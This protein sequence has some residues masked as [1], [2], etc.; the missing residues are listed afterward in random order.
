LLSEK[1]PYAINVADS[2]NPI[3]IAQSFGNI[4][5]NQDVMRESIERFQRKE[6]SYDYF[7]KKVE[8][9]VFW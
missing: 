5:A 6:G 7:A 3:E 8:K 1:Y 4:L 9:T 2:S